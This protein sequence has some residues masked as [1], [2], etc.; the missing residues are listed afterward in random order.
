V[1]LQRIRITYL[2]L[3]T[4][5]V[6]MIFVDNPAKA[7]TLVEEKSFDVIVADMRMPEMNGAEFLSEVSKIQ[8]RAVRIIL[9]GHSDRELIMQTVPVTHQFLVKPCLPDMLKSIINS[10]F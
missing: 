9:S 4:L 10:T 3:I 8:P 7:L 5:R 2:C 1:N 6:D